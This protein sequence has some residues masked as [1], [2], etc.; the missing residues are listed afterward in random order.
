MDTDHKHQESTMLTVYEFASDNKISQEPQIETNTHYCKKCDEFLPLNLFKLKGV[1]LCHSCLK[2]QYRFTKQR[3]QEIRALNTYR[4]K[5]YTDML[6][7]GMKRINIKGADILSILTK[8]QIANFTNW[9]MMPRRPDQEI[10]RDNVVM[11]RSSQRRYLVAA[12]KLSRD[13]DEYEKNLQ[14]LL[15]HARDQMHCDE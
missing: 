3:T 5:A 13:A 1:R 4:T 11:I 2:D 10:T 15:D 6:T 7:F 8:A 12:W 9:S 14:N